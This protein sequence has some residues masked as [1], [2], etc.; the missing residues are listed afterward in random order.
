MLT[1]SLPPI[2]RHAAVRMANRGV[3]K[4]FLTALVTHADV[5]TPVGDGAT[6]LRVSRN[7]ARRLNLDDRLHRY[8][9]VLSADSTVVTILPMTPTQRGRRY[10][11]A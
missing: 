2:S 9:V 5:E 1:T 4:A 11:R 8:S 6:A 7:W 10:R 3:T